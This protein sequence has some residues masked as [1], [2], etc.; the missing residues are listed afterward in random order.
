MNKSKESKDAS[1]CLRIKSSEKKQIKKLAQKKHISMGELAVEALWMYIANQEEKEI[2]N[3][4]HKL[5]KGICE[6]ENMLNYIKE[7]YKQ[8]EYLQEGVAEIWEML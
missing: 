3:D 8:D 2:G 1:L 4:I 7:K 6:L 5:T